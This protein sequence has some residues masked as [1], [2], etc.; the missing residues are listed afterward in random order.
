MYGLYRYVPL[1]EVGFQA[2]ILTYMINIKDFG[3]IYGKSIS[4]MI[5]GVSGQ[6]IV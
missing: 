6:L 5:T 3:V 1:S 2:F 4:G